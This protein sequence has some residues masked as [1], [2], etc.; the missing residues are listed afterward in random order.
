MKQDTCAAHAEQCTPNGI[1]PWYQ[2]DLNPCQNP[3]QGGELHIT[4]LSPFLLLPQHQS[5]TSERWQSGSRHWKPHPCGRSSPSA[6]IKRKD[7]SG[8]SLKPGQECFHSTVNRY[9]HVARCILAWHKSLK[10]CQSA[11]ALCGCSTDP[12]SQGLTASYFCPL[13]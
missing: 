10:S 7:C 8:K 2:P 1:T 3:C 4:R 12:R 5:D 13:L 6:A 9:Q 11:E